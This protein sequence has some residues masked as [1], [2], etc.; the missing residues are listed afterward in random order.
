MKNFL[1]LAAA[2]FVSTFFG[3]SSQKTEVSLANQ[4]VK[5]QNDSKVSAEWMSANENNRQD[6]KG[7]EEK[8]V[9][10]KNAKFPEGAFKIVVSENGFT[11]Q[12]ISYRQGQPLKL[13]F[14]RADD[15]NCGSEVIFDDLNIKKKLPVGKVVLVDIPT[16]KADEFSFACGMNVMKGKIVV[17]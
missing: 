2:I 4:N 3:C 17:Q 12:E 6:L 9:D 14:Y 8:A 11:P 16:D 1:F 10:F 5:I 15:K 13:A 7:A